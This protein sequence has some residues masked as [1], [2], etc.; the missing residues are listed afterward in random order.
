[1]IFCLR[2]NTNFVIKNCISERACMHGNQKTQE[3]DI[4]NKLASVDIYN[5]QADSDVRKL[6]Q[7][8]K[9]GKLQC[10]TFF[11]F[12]KFFSYCCFISVRVNKVL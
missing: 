5:C 6:S 3:R 9:K 2:G 10:L 1:M 4:N 12:V 7:T 11:L 8:Q